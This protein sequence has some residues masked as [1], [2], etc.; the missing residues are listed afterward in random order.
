MR[1]PLIAVVLA[2]LAA[3]A[4][5]QQQKPQPQ[6]KPPHNAAEDAKAEARLRVDGAAGGTKPVPEEARKAVGA[7]AG[8]HLKDHLPSPAKLPREEPINP[9]QGG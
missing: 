1:I 6:A 7:G 5:A 8:P 2:L 9:R 3:P 4:L